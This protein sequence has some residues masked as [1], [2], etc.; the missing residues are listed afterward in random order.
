MH[1][2]EGL[3]P[4]LVGLRADFPLET[5]RS[6]TVLRFLPTPAA[7]AMNCLCFLS[8]FFFSQLVRLIFPG[9]ERVSAAGG[10]SASSSAC[11]SIAC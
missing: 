6:M 8:R 1:H 11:R 4:E 3:R 9:K 2:Y 5:S 10:G 7:S